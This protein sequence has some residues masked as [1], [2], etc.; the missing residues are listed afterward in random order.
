MITYQCKL[1]GSH[2]VIRDAVTVWNYESQSWVITGFYDSADC[3]DCESKTL[4]E[5]VEVN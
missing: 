4:L 1:C 3:D 5:E 2:R